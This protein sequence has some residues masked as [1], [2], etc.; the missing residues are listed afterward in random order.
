[1]CHFQPNKN[2]T[3]WRPRPRRKKSWFSFK[4]PLWNAG[5]VHL[6]LHCAEKCSLPYCAWD[7]LGALWECQCTHLE[8]RDSDL[9]GPGWR[10]W[11]FL[12][13]DSLP[14]IQRHSQA[15]EPLILTLRTYGLLGWYLD[16]QRV[17]NEEL[18]QMA[19]EGYVQKGYN[20]AFSHPASWTVNTITLP[21]PCRSTTRWVS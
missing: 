1:M 11:C 12:F 16:L 10:P 7:H 4:P 17:N 8:P 2:E 6:Q 5:N 19:I 9:M 15:E 18:L 14:V 13:L 21:S 3:K 20:V